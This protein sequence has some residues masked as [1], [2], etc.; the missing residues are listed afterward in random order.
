MATTAQ[1][2]ER[3]PGRRLSVLRVTVAASLS[4]VVF[5]VLCWI[6]AR[7][8][9]GPAA[10]MFVSMYSDA[11]VTSIPALLAGICWSFLGGAILGAV[12]ALIYNGIASLER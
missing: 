10:H 8:G 4:A 3:A 12:Y 6:A 1:Q 9:F 7:I 2:A 11:D 5:V